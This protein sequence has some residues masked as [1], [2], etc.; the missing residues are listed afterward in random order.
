MNI[1]IPS[2][3]TIVINSDKSMYF[4]WYLLLDRM[5]ARIGGISGD[6]IRTN[7]TGSPIFVTPVTPPIL[8]ANSQGT[9]TFT[10]N[11]NARISFRGSDGITRS[12]NITLA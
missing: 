5:F 8:T 4:D 2:K 10:S 12:A 9:L 6:V 3:E 1:N 11:T 7:S